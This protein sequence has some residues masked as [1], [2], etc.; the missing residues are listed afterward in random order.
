MPIIMQYL[1]LNPERIQESEIIQC[2]KGILRI[3]MYIGISSEREAI[4]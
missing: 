4:N 1:I 3:Y 2:D